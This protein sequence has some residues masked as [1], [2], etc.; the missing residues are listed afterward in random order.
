MSTGWLFS[1]CG[2]L[3]RAFGFSL[4]GLRAAWKQ[5]AFRLEIIAGVPLLAF[6]MLIDVGP[7]ERAILALS[8]IL[9]VA[10]E[11]LNSAVES[12]IDRIGPEIHP[13]S[14]QA[15]DMGSAA[16]L[17]CAAGAALAWWCVLAG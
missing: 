3:R 13:L 10:V 8:V 4:S 6:S 14:K 17:V 5:A 11:L 16:V 12:A 1:E 15:K 2:R 9:V 7:A